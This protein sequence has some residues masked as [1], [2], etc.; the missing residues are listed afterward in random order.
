LN[1]SSLLEQ[2]TNNS[3]PLVIQTKMVPLEVKPK[4]KLIGGLPDIIKKQEN[5]KEMNK[6]LTKPTNNTKKK[7]KK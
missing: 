1:N 6:K 4:E 7:L 3:D 2:S 5:K